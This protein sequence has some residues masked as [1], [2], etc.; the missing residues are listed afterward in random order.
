MEYWEIT[1]KGIEA[2]GGLRNQ[3]TQDADVSAE[4]L[5]FLHR[6]E[7]STIEDITSGIPMNESTLRPLLNKLKREKWVKHQRATRCALL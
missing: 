3:V 4:V 2:L 7:A 1:T 5:V 6:R